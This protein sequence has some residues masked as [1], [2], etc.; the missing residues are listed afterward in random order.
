MRSVSLF[1]T[2]FATLLIAVNAELKFSFKSIES[3]EMISMPFPNELGTD[4]PGRKLMEGKS[5]KVELM[6][7]RFFFTMESKDGK[8]TFYQ[9]V[10]HFARGWCVPYATF[11]ESEPNQVNF[12]G[13]NGA[14]AA[15]IQWDVTPSS[16]SKSFEK[17]TLNVKDRLVIVIP[18]V[19]HQ[20][21]APSLE[22]LS[23]LTSF[24]SVERPSSDV[25]KAFIIFCFDR[26]L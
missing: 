15:I 6:T 23:S 20:P 12:S 1:S 24:Q 22:M 16:W 2:L 17:V 25:Y 8:L 26:L 19:A 7:G 9:K 13:G 18:W 11:W 14:V 4:I 5:E 10:P 21:D 3:L